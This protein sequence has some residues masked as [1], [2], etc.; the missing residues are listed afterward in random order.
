MSTAIAVHFCQQWLLIMV[1][2]VILLILRLPLLI[3]VS[4]T[5]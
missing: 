1:V 3:F 2:V 4:V 5:V